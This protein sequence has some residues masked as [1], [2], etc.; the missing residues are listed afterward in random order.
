ML[1]KRSI[2]STVACCLLM[3]GA[4][5]N[6]QQEVPVKTNMGEPNEIFIKRAL[7]EDLSPAATESNL[8]FLP[9]EKS[10][11]GQY[12][13]DIYVGENTGFSISEAKKG[14]RYSTIILTSPTGKIYKVE[15]D[16]ITCVTS[17]CPLDSVNVTIYPSDQGEIR[18]ASINN[19]NEI[20]GRWQAQIN[21]ISGDVSAKDFLVTHEASKI[22]T[23]RDSDQISL[24]NRPNKFIL[25]L[26]DL[27]QKFSKPQSTPL[28]ELPQGSYS[29]ISGTKI[30]N[31]E[32]KVTVVPRLLGSS[33]SIAQTYAVK[34]YEIDISP[35]GEIST[36][37]G[38]LPAGNY[39]LEVDFTAFMTDGEVIQRTGYYGFPVINSSVKLAGNSSSK[40]LD[41]NRLEVTLDVDQKHSDKT[42]M[43]AVYA[44]IWS[45]ET[46][47]SFINTMAN[48]DENDQLKLAID[49]RWFALAN[50][51]NR[52]NFE[53][54]N[55]K[56]L[57]PDTYLIIDE[58]KSLFV[59]VSRFP[60]AAFSR[61]SEINI[62]DSMR[63]GKQDR[64]VTSE[65]T[66]VETKNSRGAV[67]ASGIYLV[68]GWC[69]NSNAWINGHF[70]SRGVVHEFNGNNA[71][72][73][74]NN[75]AFRIRNE[76]NALFSDWFSAVAHSQGGQA[77]THLQAYYFSGLDA[78]PAPRPIQTVGT[79]YQGSVLMDLYVFS[80]AGIIKL[81]LNNN[82]CNAE[83]SLTTPSSHFWSIFLPAATQS[84]TFFYRTI[85]GLPNN[86][87]ES[88]QFWR[89]QCTVA[90][91]ILSGPDDGV[92]RAAS[93]WLL[94]GNSMG[95]TE[96]QCHTGG[97]TFPADQRDDEGRNDIMDQMGRVSGTWTAWLDRDNPSGSG[98]W[99]LR[100][101]HTGV[102][103]N[104]VDYQARRVND[105]TP[106][107]LTGEVFFH[108]SVTHGLACRNS[109]QPD[110]ICFDY[111]VRFLC[112]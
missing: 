108:N 37:I 88:L 75:F 84:E 49:S 101:D 21:G 15:N 61:A 32:A 22:L 45:D 29:T 93:A 94:F 81:L 19:R 57:D 7:M 44:E 100:A 17:A 111:E 79:P 56:L 72:F 38:G 1:F 67:D 104:P 39:S 24:V 64:Y 65:N 62:D 6:A 91:A 71:S 97:M 68:H 26:R 3:S 66:R 102:C 55:I 12:N 98:D 59:P 89:W 20:K 42:A 90:S 4:V 86:W 2:L 40:I 25:E 80:G 60:D 14:N 112:P 73:S 82:N 9:I 96:E 53:L 8:Y 13:G 31:L 43:F 74:R 23:I 41:H 92:V 85:H 34:R 33:D 54:K 95:I 51:R 18:S 70:N 110:N 5:V 77:V 52:K 28:K 99:E 105:G 58:M 30:E 48:V 87:W 16:K 35:E 36:T 69:D 109:D 103:A 10:I 46:P 11:K 78:S 27:V 76:T 50:S 107:N 63:Y 47:V 106:A 83:P